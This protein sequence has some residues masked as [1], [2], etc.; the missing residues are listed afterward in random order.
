M[1]FGGPSLVDH[2]PR[3]QWSDLQG[4]YKVSSKLA[5]GH[6]H[7]EYAPREL[8]RSPEI[9]KAIKDAVMDGNRTGLLMCIRAWTRE[10]SPAERNKTAT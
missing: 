7:G 6:C 2:V 5:T 8:L 3:R 4:V 9:I 1:T 10:R